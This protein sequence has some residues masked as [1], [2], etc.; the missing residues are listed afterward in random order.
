L[1]PL[2]NFGAGGNMAFRVD[3]LRGLGGF[4][5]CLG[6]GT[7]THGGEETKVL[8]ALLDQGS[9]VLYWPSAIT[10]HYHR[11]TD[12]ELEKQF[13]GYSA[14]LAAFYMSLL[15]TSPKYLIRILML[16]PRGIVKIIANSEPGRGDDG[17]PPGFPASLLRAGRRGLL[18]GAFLYVRERLRQRHR[19]G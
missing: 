4:D 17:P 14:G 1:Y 7:L 9:A 5:N 15:L 16:V 6:A 12:V 10:W 8:S 19:P 18:A 3:A 2:P 11:S 13:Y